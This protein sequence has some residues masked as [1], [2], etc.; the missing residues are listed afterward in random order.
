VW[1]RTRDRVH[2]PPQVF[3]IALGYDS[4]T[5]WYQTNF[6]L[7]QFHKWDATWIENL[8]PYEKHAYIDMLSKHLKHEAEVARDRAAANRRK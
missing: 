4:L 3:L 8:I 7:V 6:S 2:G 5:N 1:I